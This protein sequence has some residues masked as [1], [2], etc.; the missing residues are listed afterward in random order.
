IR[1]DIEAGCEK[2]IIGCR[3]EKVFEEVTKIIQELDEET[4]TKTKV[5][6]L[7][8]ILNLN[9]EELIRI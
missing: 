1:K 4:Q 2:V 7:S 6:L 9:F 3:D 5:L 8:K